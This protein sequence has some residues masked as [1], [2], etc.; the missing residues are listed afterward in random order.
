M[1]PTSTGGTANATYHVTSGLGPGNVPCAGKNQ[2][3]KFT[4]IFNRDPTLISTSEP[5]GIQIAVQADSGACAPMNPTISTSPQGYFVQSPSLSEAKNNVIFQ[6]PAG[7]TNVVERSIEASTQLNPGGFSIYL[8]G[9]SGGQGALGIRLDYNYQNVPTA[10]LQPPAGGK[11]GC[12][13]TSWVVS[14]MSGATLYE[15]QIS[16]GGAPCTNNI[17]TK[18]TQAS[19]QIVT[20]PAHGTLTQ[21]G[22]LSLVYKPAPGFHGTDH[23]VFHYCGANALSSGCATINYTVQVQ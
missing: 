9:G 19:V 1:T 16:A 10:A 23:Y 3:V 14:P 18:L 21:T 20:P 11:P 12:T 7:Y 17:T 6:P 13:S 2:N 4:W 15:Q 8:G 22:T 5:L